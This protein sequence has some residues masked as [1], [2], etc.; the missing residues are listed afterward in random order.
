MMDHLLISILE[1][2]HGWTKAF[3]KQ[4]LLNQSIYAKQALKGG[5]FMDQ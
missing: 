1:K 3:L 5:T 4:Q 2:I